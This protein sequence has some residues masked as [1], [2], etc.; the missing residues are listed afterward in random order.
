MKRLLTPSEIGARL[1]A[2]EKWGWPVRVAHDRGSSFGKIHLVD[3]TQLRSIAVD[4]D[5][6]SRYKFAPREIREVYHSEV[7]SNEPDVIVLQSCPDT[8]LHNIIGKETRQNKTRS[9]EVSL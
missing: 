9:L 4:G 8:K 2:A 6:G 1:E 3:E 7:Q 5:G